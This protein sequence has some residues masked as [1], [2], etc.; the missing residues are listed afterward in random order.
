[1]QRGGHAYIMA[2]R[3]LGTLY[4]GVTANLPVR[5][6]QHR[7]AT[8]RAFT[9]RYGVTRLVWAEWFDDIRDAIAAEKRI[10]KMYRAEKVA[11]I[12]SLNPE[13]RDLNPHSGF[14]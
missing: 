10:K 1:L 9:G 11:L 3:R 6:Y 7:H 14:G 4:T 5:V 12:E 13:W 8:P 2:S